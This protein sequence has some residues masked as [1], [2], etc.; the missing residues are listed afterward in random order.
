MLKLRGRVCCAGVNNV[1]KILFF[2]HGLSANGIETFL[3]N[4][5]GKLNKEKYD[6]TVLIAIDEGVPSLHE[7]TVRK[8]GVRIVNAGDLDTVGKKLAYIKNV[9]NEL[10]NGNYDIVHSN[11]DLLNGITLHFARRAGVKMR[12][13]HAHNSKSQYAPGGRLAWLKKLV[14]KQYVRLMKASI[15]RNS[16]VL[17]SCSE[18][19]GEYFYGDRPSVLV[20]NGVELGRFVM[21]ENFSRSEY[22]KN[23]GADDVKTVISVGRLSMQ[24]N[25]GFAMDVIKELKKLRSDFQ[26]IWVGSGGL[27]D[28]MKNKV[29]ED[30]LEDTVIFT[31]VRTDVPRLLNCADCFFMPSL[32]EGLPFSLVEAQAAGLRCLVSDVVSPTADCGLIDF[33]PLEKSPREWAEK[34][35]G[36][37]DA[38]AGKADGGRLMRFDINYTVKQLEEI[39]G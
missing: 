16:T 27:E 35:S 7:E 26:Y 30:G 11:M 9:R 28:E 12:I 31:G 17:L 18:L 2:S 10:K 14:Q 21:P 15:L 39:Y 1:K 6:I 24:K 19:A 20:Y 37:L 23:I 34:M 8:M 25:P 32:F 3:V 22:L 5:L 38:P 33:V 29:R 4:V 36:I 13:C